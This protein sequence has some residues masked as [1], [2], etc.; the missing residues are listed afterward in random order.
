MNTMQASKNHTM[1]GWLCLISL[2]SL[3]P[4]SGQSVLANS[5][6]G[7][8]STS[9]NAP[10]VLPPLLVS[11][12]FT[13]LSFWKPESIPLMTG[14]YAG[15]R[16]GAWLGQKKEDP[17]A[18]HPKAALFTGLAGAMLGGALG[19]AY[20]LPSLA[21][22]DTQTDGWALPI[23]TA[24]FG[25]GEYY[26]EWEF[27]PSRNSDPYTIHHHHY[28]YNIWSPNR[29]RYHRDTE[30]GSIPLAGA[31]FAT[32]LQEQ[33]VRMIL[34]AGVLLD[35][36]VTH[37]QNNSTLKPKDNPNNEDGPCTNIPCEKAKTDT[38]TKKTSSQKKQKGEGESQ[39]I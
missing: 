14:M 19:H 4:I 33:T 16:L 12:V 37:L 6:D 18:F 9:H 32:L 39:D 8:K 5:Q 23:M 38:L 27:V 13:L 21:F 31:A 11:G 3:T 10:P 24:S 1:L 17:E 35:I 30:L 20:L 22:L 25:I 2:A 29:N 36:F 28:M 26:R 15:W 34:A 7:V